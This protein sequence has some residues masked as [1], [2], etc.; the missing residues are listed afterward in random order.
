MAFV[1]KFLVTYQ[2]VLDS[3]DIVD[4]K[5]K[6]ILGLIW[7]LILHYSISMP[8]W[9]GEE[10]FGE[11]K[12]PTPKQRLLHWIQSRVP[13]LPIT[14]FTAD[15]NDGRAV[16]A[17]VDAVAPG[18]C[19]DWQDWNPTDSLQNA[20][21]AMGLA[22]DWLNVR[23]LA[24]VPVLLSQTTEDGEI[25]VRI[26]V[27]VRAYGPGIEPS[28]PVVGAPA[29][30]T[31]ETFSAGKG[32]VDVAIENPHG[33]VEPV[34]IRFN[35]D[36]NLTY[37]VSYTPKLEGNHKVSVKFAGREIPKSPYTVLVEGHA[38]DASKVTASGPGLQP[39]GVMINRPTYFDISTK[40]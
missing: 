2:E 16:G 13:D 15:W 12:G 39:E 31:V 33:E 6:L 26:S 32:Q 24:N 11:G 23:Q 22:D 28:G 7:T 25:E 35:K 4:C 1:V 14:N 38:G 34:D 20:S 40:G 10:D 37:S 3:T 5:L 9:E 30:F 17:L 8:M 29:N 27:G 18:L 21:E 36:R 19:P